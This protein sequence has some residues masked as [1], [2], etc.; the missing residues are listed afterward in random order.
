MGILAVGSAGPSQGQQGTQSFHH[1]HPRQ[2]GAI[3]AAVQGWH[4][5]VIIWGSNVGRIRN[6]GA[7][8]ELLQ[9][10]KEAAVEDLCRTKH[11]SLCSSWMLPSRGDWDT[12]ELEA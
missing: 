8:T 11:L 4:H 10:F 5:D 3:H 1:T 6:Q 12:K 9:A 2:I 7:G